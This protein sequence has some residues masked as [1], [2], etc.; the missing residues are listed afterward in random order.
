MR[1]LNSNHLTS[2][3]RVGGQRKKKVSLKKLTEGLTLCR[4]KQNKVLYKMND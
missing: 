1:L 4:N 3:W 2:H